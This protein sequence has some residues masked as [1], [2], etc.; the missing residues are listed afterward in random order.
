M[1]TL[2]D[3]LLSAL[4]QTLFITVLAIILV[5]LTLTGPLTRTAKWLRGLRTGQVNVPPKG[6]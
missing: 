6:G 1:H 4:I 2:R 3:S 5:R